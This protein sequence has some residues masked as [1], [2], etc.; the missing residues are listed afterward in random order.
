MIYIITG[1]AI[2]C[3][4]PFKNFELFPSLDPHYY[5]CSVQTTSTEVETVF[6]RAINRQRRFNV[7][8][9][10]INCGMLQCIV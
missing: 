6:Q 10:P 5:Q 8:G 9:L 3:R 2:Q 4:D 1:F 7:A